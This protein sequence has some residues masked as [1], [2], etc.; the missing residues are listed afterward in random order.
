M[1][2]KCFKPK[3]SFALALC[4]GL[5]VSCGSDPASDNP[6]KETTQ[7][8]AAE[9]VSQEDIREVHVARLEEQKNDLD[10]IQYLVETWNRSLNENNQELMLLVYGTQVQYYKKSMK[11]TEVI[12]AKKRALATSLDYEQSIVHLAVHYP[13]DRP[14]IICCEFDKA[15]SAGGKSDT[16]RALLE[17]KLVNE[18]YRIVKEGDYATEIVMIKEEKARGL[19]KGQHHYLYDYWLDTRE[20]EA[21]AHDFVPYYLSVT[22]NNGGEKPTVDLNWYSGSLRETFG[23]VTRNVRLDGQYLRFEAAAMMTPDDD[24]D[25]DDFQSFTFK[26]LGD[27]IAL[28]ENDGWFTEMLGIRLW[29]VKDE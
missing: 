11:R 5:T 29:G 23:F 7:E 24:E 19:S 6:E 4:L 20:D 28:I 25:L 9:A 16:A 17:I 15:W 13:S 10:S 3:F 18:Q 27:E 2:L 14:G 26:L 1:S 8:T 12:E 21:L 22:V